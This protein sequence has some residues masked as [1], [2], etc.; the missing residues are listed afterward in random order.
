MKGNVDLF[1]NWEHMWEGKQMPTEAERGEVLWKAG[2][3]TR[4][5]VAVRQKTKAGTREPFKGERAAVGLG[6][7]KY[8]TCI[9]PNKQHPE[10]GQH[11]WIST[12]P[13]LFR[14]SFTLPSRCLNRN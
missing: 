1:I 12:R 3:G 14:K 2:E 10:Q 5:R 6:Q 4:S 13:L 11:S 8:I 9:I 7:L